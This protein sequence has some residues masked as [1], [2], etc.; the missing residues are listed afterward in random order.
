MR[1]QKYAV[2]GLST[3]N[4][5]FH[6][7]KETFQTFNIVENWTKLHISGW[8]KL[9]YSN[10]LS[11]FFVHCSIDKITKFH[12]PPTI[13]LTNTMIISEKL[14]FLPYSSLSCHNQLWFCFHQPI[15]GTDGMPKCKENRHLQPELWWF[16]ST[17]LPHV[18]YLG[19]F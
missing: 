15:T 19:T 18:V 16:P 1:M 4:S 12:R 3:F 10:H 7:K 11:V 9:T 14:N 17:H 2:Y 13:S 5:E 8:V 6:L